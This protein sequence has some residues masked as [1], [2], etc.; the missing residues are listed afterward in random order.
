MKSKRENDVHRLL[1]FESMLMVENE[2]APESLFITSWI[3]WVDGEKHCY[4]QIDG[5]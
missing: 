2:S 4:A 1:V 3:L 5:N